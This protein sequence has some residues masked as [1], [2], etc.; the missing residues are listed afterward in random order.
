MIALFVHPLSDVLSPVAP[1]G[2][3]AQQKRE[4]KRGFKKKENIEPHNVTE[5]FKRR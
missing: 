1:C 4:L 5:G 2:S 3:F